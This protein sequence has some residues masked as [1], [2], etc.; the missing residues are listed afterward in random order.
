MAFF[1]S[2]IKYLITSMT[3][4]LSWCML[5]FLFR[6]IFFLVPHRRWRS[7]LLPLLVIWILLWQVT[8]LDPC[9]I[10]S[11]R[12]IFFLVPRRLVATPPGYLT[13]AQRQRALKRC[14]DHLWWA[15]LYPQTCKAE[16]H[17]KQDSKA[18]HERKEGSCIR[19][20][21][22]VLNPLISEYTL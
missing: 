12:K 18:N 17:C 1:A 8:F 15:A 21:G 16:H 4:H 14:P 9:W 22:L 11:F 19:D 3:I 6:E 10:S 5:N 2:F 13:Y 7:T 20:I